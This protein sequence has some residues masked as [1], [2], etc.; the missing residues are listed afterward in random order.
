MWPRLRTPPV[1][2]LRCVS[3]RM[4]SC[5]RYDQKRYEEITKE[6]GNYIKRV[7]YNPAKVHLYPA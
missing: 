3:L 1:Q 2:L 5:G 7:G 6:V 4:A